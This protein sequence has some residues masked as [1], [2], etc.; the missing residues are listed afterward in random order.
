MNQTSDTKPEPPSS[1][2]WKVRIWLRGAGVIHVLSCTKPVVE[3]RNGIVLDVQL[4]IIE[5]T[6]HGDSIDFIDWREVSAITYRPG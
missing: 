5:D 3:S 6:E 4:S 1:P 2:S